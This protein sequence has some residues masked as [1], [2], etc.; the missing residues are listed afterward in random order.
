M[1]LMLLQKSAPALA[2]SQPRRPPRKKAPMAADSAED[3][4][5]SAEHVTP[6]TP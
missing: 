6:A 5:I 3:R 4:S 1:H 2:D